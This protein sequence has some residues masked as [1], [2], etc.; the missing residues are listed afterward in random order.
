VLKYLPIFKTSKLP[1]VTETH[2]ST[3]IFNHHL[4]QH[5]RGIGDY[6]EVSADK[7]SK[8]RIHQL[9]RHFSVHQNQLLHGFA[10][11]GN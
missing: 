8:V 1:L 2:R 6:Y 7:Q 10:F 5:Q 11:I 3:D 9:T 4:N